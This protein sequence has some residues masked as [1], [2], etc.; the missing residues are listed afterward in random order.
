MR[1]YEFGTTPALMVIQV[2]ETQER[3]EQ[4]QTW[5][6]ARFKQAP[7]LVNHGRRLLFEAGHILRSLGE[8]L[9]QYGL[10]Q[11]TG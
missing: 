5:Y 8:Q 7:W 4:R 2:K 3:W 9:Q 1:D 6:V 10:P 11:P